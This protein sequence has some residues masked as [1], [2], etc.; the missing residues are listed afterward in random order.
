MR[1]DSDFYFHKPFDGEVVRLSV[2]TLGCTLNSEK[3]L[4]EF[5]EKPYVRNDVKLLEGT[6]LSSLFACHK[7][8][9]ILKLSCPFQKMGS[10]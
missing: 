4:N 2:P 1:S 5:H 8:M 3:I 9:N 10:M 6:R 7:T